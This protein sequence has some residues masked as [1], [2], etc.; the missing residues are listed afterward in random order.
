MPDA[1]TAFDNCIDKLKEI[2]Q[3]HF[4]TFQNDKN[5]T[6]EYCDDFE[7]ADVEI[8]INKLNG[9]LNALGGILIY[10]GP[11]EDSPMAFLKIEEFLSH[12]ERLA[13]EANQQLNTLTFFF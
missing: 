2:E 3:N 13:Q 6:V 4:E 9:L 1:K 8:I 10:K 11:D 12:I 5:E 7:K